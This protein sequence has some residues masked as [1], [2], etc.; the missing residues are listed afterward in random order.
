MALSQG[1]LSQGRSGQKLIY[2]DA[3]ETEQLIFNAFN[4][5]QT[6]LVIGA[7]VCRR[8]RDQ[9]KSDEEI[10]HQISWFDHFAEKCR[11]IGTFRDSRVGEILSKLD[12]P[13]ELERHFVEIGFGRKIILDPAR[14][15]C[16]ADRKNL[17]EFSAMSGISFV[18]RG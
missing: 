9:G 5:R 11:D 12:L 1:Y 7:I 15:T 17:M 3:A 13:A 4:P 6:M 2:A 8:F 10:T 14:R 18:Y 16:I